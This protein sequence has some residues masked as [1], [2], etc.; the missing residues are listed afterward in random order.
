MSLVITNLH[1]STKDGK[2][3]L[4][5][6]TLTI[7]KGEKHAIMGPNGGG[8]S[9]LAH[10]LMGHPAYV[11]TKGSIVLNGLNLHKTSYHPNAASTES[12]AVLSKEGEAVASSTEEKQL[13]AGDDALGGAGI[14][15]KSS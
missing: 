12:E 13:M 3:I 10:V 15:R 1:A 4:R 14:L 5:G 2:E 11:V 9:T 8:K 6:L 7:N